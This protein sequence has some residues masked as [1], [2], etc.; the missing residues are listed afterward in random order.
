MAKPL[1]EAVRNA[2]CFLFLSQRLESTRYIPSSP[3]PT[4]VAE[5]CAPCRCLVGPEVLRFGL[6]AAGHVDL[7]LL[8]FADSSTGS[9]WNPSQSAGSVK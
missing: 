9:E 4:I 6:L 8:P 5:E 3:T 2:I 7:S 1:N